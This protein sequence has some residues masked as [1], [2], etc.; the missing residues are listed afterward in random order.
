M[1]LSPPFPIWLRA[2][3]KLTSWP[4]LSMASCHA[5]AWRSTESNSVPSMSKIAAFVISK[6]SMV[7]AS[8]SRIPISVRRVLHHV[9]IEVR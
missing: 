2:C 4:N 5:S 3:S 1:S 6:S 7:G 9:T 8:E